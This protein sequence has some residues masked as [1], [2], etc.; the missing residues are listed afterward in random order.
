LLD[1]AVAFGV[2]ELHADLVPVAGLAE[3]VDESEGLGCVG[4]V[5]GY[6]EAKLGIAWGFEGFGVNGVLCGGHGFSL[7]VLGCDLAGE[8]WFVS[9]PC[10]VEIVVLIRTKESSER[11]K[12]KL[13]QMS[14]D[15]GVAG[16]KPC[17]APAFNSLRSLWVRVEE[18]IA[19]PGVWWCMRRAKFVD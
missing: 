19:G 18:F 13:Q 14:A 8:I 10:C 2:E 16:T 1:D 7:A 3:T 5:E 15:L 4:V 9:P 6:G 12:E 11:T 17:W